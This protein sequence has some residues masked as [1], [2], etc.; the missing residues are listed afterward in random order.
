MLWHLYF[1]AETNT[2]RIINLVAQR[3]VNAKNMLPNFKL[4]SLD[5]CQ[6]V[7]EPKKQKKKLVKLTCY[8][9]KY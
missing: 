4:V 6:Q 2:S 9:G 3:V 7:K 5:A 8:K 1:P